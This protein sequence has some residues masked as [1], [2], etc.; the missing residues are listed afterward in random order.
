MA[1][2]LDELAERWRADAYGL[3]GVLMDLNRGEDVALEHGTVEQLEGAVAML[4]HVL[5]E[6]DAIR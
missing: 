6:L 3:G 2:R 1:D 5:D 4:W